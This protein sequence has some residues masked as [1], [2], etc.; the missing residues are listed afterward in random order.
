MTN[1]NY[2]TEATNVLGL[3]HQVNYMVYVEGK[4]DI[5]FWEILLSKFSSLK[6]EIQEVNGCEELTSFIEG[7]ASGELNIIVAT[8]S[9]FSIF[10]NKKTSHCN[11]LRTFGYSIENS[12]LNL[13]V[14]EKTIK[15]LGRLSKEDISK[16]EIS[17]WLSN[18]IDLLEELI[19]IDIYNHIFKCSASVISDTVHP[20]LLKKGEVE[21]CEDKINEHVENLKTVIHEYDSLT[22]DKIIEEKST[23]YLHWIKGH[24]LF[25]MVANY[26]RGTLTKI[27]KK[28]N[29][30]DDALYAQF[31]QSYE[32][33]LDADN[34][35]NNYYKNI[36]SHIT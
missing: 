30:S 36:V 26:I 27:G 33:C 35:E 12:Y 16:I 9:D 10:N 8:D 19:K 22:I 4:D 23:L 21:L 7:I 14:I 2:S 28:T 29:V 6:F 34:E 5:C 31:I 17:S 20:F 1:W 13:S 32:N 18:Q 3:F 11:I 15:S 25:S 24:F